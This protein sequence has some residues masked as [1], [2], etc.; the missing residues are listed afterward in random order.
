MMLGSAS[1]AVVDDDAI[2]GSPCVLAMA[3]TPRILVARHADL[4]RSV[5]YCLCLWWVSLYNGDL[6]SGERH[7]VAEQ[8]SSE[9]LGR[10]TPVSR[11][12]SLSVR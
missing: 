1:V 8:M 9:L 3:P 12:R 2:A 11:V 7:T 4:Q 5:A 6:D 10:T